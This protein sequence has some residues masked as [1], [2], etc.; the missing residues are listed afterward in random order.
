MKWLE[1]FPAKD[2][3]AA[4]ITTLLVEQTISRHGVPTE[5][6]SDRGKAFLSALFKEV[7][8]FLGFHKV[9]ITAYHPQKDGCIGREVQQN[10]NGYA[11]QD[12]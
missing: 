3:S 4:T 8:K 9:N 11:S 12:H 1:V 10:T 2:Q 5:V 7:E 6:L